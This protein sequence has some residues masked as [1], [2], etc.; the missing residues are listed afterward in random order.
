MSDTQE[1]IQKPKTRLKFIDMARSVAI[2]LM[3]EGHFI[4]HTFKYFKPMVHAVREKGTSG[5]FIFDWFYF[6]KGFTAPLFFT[7]TGIVFV[8]L[9]A[10]N[11]DAGYFRNPRVKKGFKRV[12]E[13]LFW[14]Y[15]LQLA[16][17]SQ[18]HNYLKGVFG[19][20]VSAFHV[21]QCI[22]IGI[23]ALLV[24]Y[25]IYKLVHF[26]PLYLW[27][28][29]AGI[30]V[31][32]FYPWMHSLPDNKFLPGGAP[33]VFQNMIHGPNSVFAIVPW[34]SFTLL[35]GMIGAILIRFQDNVKKLWF[36]IVFIAIGLILNLWGREI[37]LGIDDLLSML[38]FHNSDFVQTKTLFGRFG[39]ILIA[40][41]IFMLIEKFF[42]PKA[43]LF[44]KVGANTLPIYVI[45]VIILYGGLFGYGLKDFMTHTLSGW[46]T[47]LGAV[48]FIGT[49]VVFIKY[50]EF[51]TN[52]WTKI[53]DFVFFWRNSTAKKD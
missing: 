46:Q 13:L 14:G 4:E 38:G 31:L 20:W 3:L 12:A 48:L 35:G 11:K 28:F 1:I 29:I 17:I 40:L 21:L 7:V 8:Y 37:L 2:L 41:G 22:G 47:V 34:M 30:V 5:W 6:M 43:E 42:D 10:R 53:W 33:E 26:I 24:I 9:L 44:L 19:G 23:A 51:F 18:G 52:I 27:Y 39:Q 45:H 50:L 16:I 49:F 32:S 36:P 15:M 25:G